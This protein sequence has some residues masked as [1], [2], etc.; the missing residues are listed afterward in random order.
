MADPTIKDVLKAIAEMRGEMATKKELAA[1]DAKMEARFDAVDARFDA[2]DARFDAVD[3]RFDA[4][5]ARFDAVDKSIA[6]LGADIDKHMV[7]H[8]KLEKQVEILKVKPARPVARMPRR[9]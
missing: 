1:F 5:D 9:R 4:V 6:E 7:V 8:K 2:V 3:A